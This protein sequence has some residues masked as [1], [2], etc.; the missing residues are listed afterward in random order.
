MA[1]QYAVVGQG[2]LPA[3]LSDGS[4]KSTAI[5]GEFVNTSG[6]IT[7]YT[8]TA[9]AGSFAITGV[10]AGL[11]AARKLTASAG[12][13]A[14]TGNN[15]TLTWSGAPVV[16]RR[17]GRSGMGM[18]FGG[19]GRLG[20]TRSPFSGSGSVPSS[21]AL[22]DY[23]NGRVFQRTKSATT[24]RLTV[25][26]TYTG[27]APSIILV[28]CHKS[29]DNSVVLSWRAL[30]DTTIAGGNWSGTLMSVP[31]GGG[32]Y[33]KVKPQGGDSL[34]VTGG[35]SFYMGDWFICYGQ[36]FM[37]EMFSRASSPAAA[38]AGTG[39][40]DGSI[41]TT[42]PA[43]NGVR[44][45]LNT[46]LSLTGIPC[47]AINGAVNGTPI[48]NLVQGDGIGN[49]NNL[50][51][52]LTGCGGDAAYILWFHGSSDADALTS[53]ATYVSQLKTGI[54]NALCTLTGRT[55][56]QLPFL[57]CGLMTETGGGTYTDAGWAT[58]QTALRVCA[59][60]LP[61]VYYSHGSQDLALIDGLHQTA[62][63][64]GK[65]GDR[66]ARTAAYINGSVATP[67]SWFATAAAV[68]DGTHSTITHEFGVG[69]DFTPTTGITG[70]DVSDDDG[71]T[72]NACTGVRASATT[73]TL[74]HVSKGNT[75]LFRYLY[76]LNPDTSGIMLDNSSLALPLAPTGT[77]YLL[78]YTAGATPTI[79]SVAGV[80]DSAATTHAASLP[81]RIYKG[82]LLLMECASYD[83][84][85]TTPTGWTSLESATT[86]GGLFTS[87][88][89]KVADGS[90]ATSVTVALAGSARLSSRAVKIIGQKSS[91]FIEI[92]TPVSGNTSGPDP[93]TVTPS[94]GSANNLW[95]VGAM[96]RSGGSTT[97]ISAYP[98]GYTDNQAEST[99]NNALGCTA[100]IASKAATASSD[101]PAAW[102]LAGARE[103]VA[104]T[105]AV[106]P[107]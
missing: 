1:K 88:F 8:L 42:P 101:N 83:Q 80:A 34:T 65:A 72:W 58:I 5:Y 76:G 36:S 96:A 18:G 61:N 59:D 20:A 90:E 2:G 48:D 98:S 3:Y 74:T 82:S 77:N 78:A 70:W 10:A 84:A 107:T 71:V 68:V 13:F 54:H 22:T 29:S 37:N 15:A 45:L 85:I 24:G 39:Y 79:A 102:T 57:L 55:T 87:T 47:A 6:G 62:A 4:T 17:G 19:F 93:G 73:V 41:F 21:F 53:A 23:T 89:Y 56:A 95:I 50:S 104:T 64:S 30:V 16:T 40:F 46:Y 7:N 33:L 75:R 31:T 27:S 49:F 81:A 32:Y 105:I 25:S 91:G 35:T 26:G 94:W 43:A 100:A 63:S 12:S 69:T 106:R 44:Q 11:K 9:A 52:L 28:Q 99:N 97:L 66:F 86:S 14:I 67:T 60:T 51:G 38:S 92:A 103:V